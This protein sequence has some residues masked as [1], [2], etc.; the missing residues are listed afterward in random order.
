MSLMMSFSVSCIISEFEDDP[1]L[2][3]GTSTVSMNVQFRPLISALDGDETKSPGGSIKH[4]E[5]LWVVVYKNDGTW[6]KTVQI[7]PYGSTN[8]YNYNNSELN[9]SDTNVS[10]PEGSSGFA[11]S[12]YCH[13]TFD[14]ELPLGKYRIYAVVNHDL[15]SFSGTEDE[16][17]SI[18]LQWNSDVAKNNQ[19]FGFFTD[20]DSS[21]IPS[22][23][24][25]ISIDRASKSLH[26]WVKRAA[27]KVTVS[28]DGSNLYENIYIYIHSIQIKDIPTTCFL[29]K[30]NSP[31]S[32][33][34][35]IASGETIY[36]RNRSSSTQTEGLRI[37]K[38]LPTG[39]QDTD[40]VHGE[41]AEAL[42]FYENMQGTDPKKHQYNNFESKD[43][44][45][46]GTYIEV[47]GYYVNKTADNASQ[48][49]IIYRFMLGKNV[50]DD[51]N[52][53]RSNHY[54]VVLKFRN[55][56][57]DPDWHIEYEPE[58]PEIS[59]PSPM[60]ISYGYNEVLNIPVIVRGASVNSNTT[61]RA[62]IIENPWGYPEHKYYNKSNHDDLNDGFLSL[63]NKSGVVSIS[64]SQR[65]SWDKEGS[66][67]HSKVYPHKTDL[68]AAYYS[69]PVYTRPLILAN[70]LTGHNPYVSHERKA[71]VKFTVTM[72]GK[73]YS[74]TI[75][76]IQ[77]KRL[78][79]PA[80][81]WRSDNN[82]SPFNI[83]LM[84]L[85]EPDADEN[86]M[87]NV[88]FV[89]PYSDGP[90]TAHIEEG[91]DWVQIAPTGSGNWGTSDVT[92][93]TGSEIRFDYR[94]KNANTTGNVRCGVIKVTYHNNTC[95]H[96][97]FVSQGNGTINIAG[98]KWQNRNVLKKNELVANPLMEGSMFKFG[99]PNHGILVE[100][101]HR[102]GYGFQQD[103]WGKLFSST[104][105]KDRTFESINSNLTAG[106]TNTTDSDCR[107]FTNTTAKPSTYNQWASLETLHR[108]YG[109]LYGDEC[110]A[111]MTNTIDAYSY[112]QVGQQRGMQGMFV[113]DE[114]KG[115][116]HIFFPIGSTGNGHRQV[117]DNVQRWTTESQEHIPYSVL[118]YAQRSIE[119]QPETS[120]KLPMY[121]DLWIR[122]G[123]IYWYYKKVEN[124][125]EFQG[126]TDLIGYSHD[127][128][129]HT[130]LLQTYS[131][132][133]SRVTDKNG[134][135]SSDAAYIRCVEP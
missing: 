89:A 18:N 87:R 31:D 116:N 117:S 80:G 62:E 45:P 130:M 6:Y 90:W 72:D 20:N 39:G 126:T 108:R 78:V 105:G 55:S 26:A 48:G 7:Y 36:L 103:C 58:S 97:V 41:N 67:Y 134:N 56:A 91:S 28:F 15:G 2:S 112:Y 133:G 92:G 100:N 21:E 118:K 76:V 34:E 27:S 98:S 75:E 99:N 14:M 119:M 68:T 107:I 73:T 16:L 88:N 93:G 127:I 51:F 10:A 111:T 19:M 38:G 110:N 8:T 95:V 64:E 49:E 86:G 29:G 129:F 102:D 94:P 128:N 81:V 106:F 96:Y 9:T 60:Y 52:A 69:I 71:T 65:N 124:A 132:N 121:Y 40:V 12:T 44:K 63:E 125:R 11:E 1:L 54:K 53:E 115:G 135:V 113:W 32:A 101:N 79:N 50:T 35:L 46:F 109:V 59:V 77:V 5:S 24:P 22:E 37:T 13:S 66:K 17:K 42:F 83:R 57:N 25:V 47:K 70:S 123:A 61:I 74:Q 84:E 120:V 33:S 43:N 85:N 82:T 4:I 104:D 114:E 23:V 3:E 131:E 30:Q 122:K